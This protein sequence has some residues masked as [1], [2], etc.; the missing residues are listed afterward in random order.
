MSISL[1]EK[2]KKE[3]FQKI[4]SLQFGIFFSTVIL[5]ST[6]FVSQELCWCFITLLLLWILHLCIQC[7]A[8]EMSQIIM[9]KLNQLQIQIKYIHYV[10]IRRLY[11]Y[12]GLYTVF[13][14]GFFSCDACTMRHAARFSCLSD[15]YWHAGLQS[16]DCKQTSWQ[17]FVTSAESLLGVVN[18]SQQ[19][20]EC[21][22]TVALILRKFVLLG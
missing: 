21:L 3:M 1:S 12:E 2:R 10:M 16:A 15:C 13:V 5:P 18:I 8:Q 7:D 20:H 4:Y 11:V 6:F 14:S 22:A 17:G 9:G 19:D